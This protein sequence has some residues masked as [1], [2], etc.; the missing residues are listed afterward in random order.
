MS[1][2]V[3]RNKGRPLACPLFFQG[4]GSGIGACIAPLALGAATAIAV[5]VLFSIFGFLAY[6]SLPLLHSGSVGAVLSWQWAPAAGQF[7]I[8]AML[9]GTTLVAMPALLIAFPM[10][11]GIVALANGLAP[12][13]MA[14]LLLGLVQFM[15][16]VPTVVWAFVSAFLVVP[17]VRATTATS[18]FSWLAVVLTLAILILPTIVLVLSTQLRQ[19]PEELRLAAASLGFD[20]TQYLLYVA[21]PRIRA[22][23]AAALVLAC[24]RAIGD[25][26]I[27][28]MVSGNAPIVPQG[29]FDSLRTLT[30]HIAL[31][32]S[33]DSQSVAYASLFASGLLLCLTS[34][35]LNLALLKI[36]GGACR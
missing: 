23:F 30:A 13:F 16:S 4:S 27:A 11:V 20:R 6:F 24:G 15:T 9:V 1:L 21:F 12:S 14:R 28:L 8:L 7:G 35:L 2:S 3:S 33:T 26:I 31:V 29:P 32:L 34:V 22:S 10:G 36:R 17:W 18:G 19:L 25:T 5:L